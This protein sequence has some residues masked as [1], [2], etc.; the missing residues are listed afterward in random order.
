MINSKRIS[1]PEFELVSNPKIYLDDIKYG[2][3]AC[4]VCHERFRDLQSHM[5]N[6]TDHEHVVAS[7]LET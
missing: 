3:R 6:M 4:P 5:S 2:R 1:V 7:I